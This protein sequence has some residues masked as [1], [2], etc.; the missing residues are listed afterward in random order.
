MSPKSL[1]C[2]LSA[3]SRQRLVRIWTANVALG[4]E[5]VYLEF[6]HG[7]S[8]P[9]FLA[10]PGCEGVHFLRLDDARQAVVTLWVDD[11]AVLACEGSS[12]YRQTAAD[13]L[14][15]GVIEGK[16]SVTVLA[17]APPVLDVLS[18]LLE[19]RPSL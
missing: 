6:A 12:H 16:T 19:Q 3:C 4:N 11:A 8:L 10:Q 17:M 14:A 2:E 13:L 15:T 7:R 18:A 9:M 5:S 1:L